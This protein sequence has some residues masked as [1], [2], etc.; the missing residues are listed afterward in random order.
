MGLGFEVG[1]REIGVYDWGLRIL[2]WVL[3]LGIGDEDWDCRLGIGD[4]D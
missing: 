3:V 4:W 1:N 2:E